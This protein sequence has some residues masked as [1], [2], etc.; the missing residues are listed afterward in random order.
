MYLNIK[1]NMNPETTCCY[2]T[3]FEVTEGPAHVPF[4]GPFLYGVQVLTVYCFI[5]TKNLIFLLTGRLK[6]WDEQDFKFY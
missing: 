3:Y 2:F 4:S 5:F 1:N 6:E